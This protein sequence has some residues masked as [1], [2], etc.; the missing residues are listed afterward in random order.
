MNKKYRKALNVPVS[1]D[2]RTAL[3][4]LQNVIE[5]K[6]GKKPPQQAVIRSL[7]K[8]AYHQQVA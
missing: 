3:M 7:I 2:T 6:T 4:F 8:A 5:E 1:E